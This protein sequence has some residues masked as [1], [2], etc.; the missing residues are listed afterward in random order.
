MALLDVTELLTDA[1]F[2][3]DFVLIR[4]EFSV[5]RFG[6]NEYT[7]TTENCTGIVQPTTADVENLLPT[8]ANPTDYIQVWMAEKLRAGYDAI[9]W[10]GKVYAVEQV[11]DW[12]H[13]GSGFYNAV[14]KL[15]GVE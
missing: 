13:Y 5:N 7:E 8:G 2:C 6:E 11:K 3:N 1:D 4:K 10:N 12:A 14:C 15:E 9:L